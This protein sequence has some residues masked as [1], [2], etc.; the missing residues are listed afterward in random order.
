[1]YKPR[2]LSREMTRVKADL[3]LRIGF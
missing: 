1:M 3:K 2:K